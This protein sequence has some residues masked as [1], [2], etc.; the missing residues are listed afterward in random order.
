MKSIDMRLLSVPEGSDADFLV[1]QPPFEN[2]LVVSMGNGP[3][4]ENV[5]ASERL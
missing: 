1:R 3:V 2:E 5:L 4:Q